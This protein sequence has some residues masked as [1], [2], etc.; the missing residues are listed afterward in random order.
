LFW[1]RKKLYEVASGV[2]GSKQVTYQFTSPIPEDR[3]MRE[4]RNAVQQGLPDGSV[5]IIP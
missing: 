3:A 2:V 4:F 5:I 1:R